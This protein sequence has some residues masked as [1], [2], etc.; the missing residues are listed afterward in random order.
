MSTDLSVVVPVYGSAPIVDELARRLRA[1][2]EASS[3]RWE[4]LLV[5]DDSPDGAWARILEVCEADPRFRGLRLM[6]NQ[7]QHIATLCGL[8]HASGDLVVTMDDDLQHRPEDIPRLVAALDG[9]LDCVMAA[10]PRKRHGPLRNLASRLVSWLNRR[11]YRLPPG[12]RLSTFRVLRGSVVRRM[13]DYRVSRPAVAQLVFLSTSRVA[14][15][16][17]PHDERF[18]GRSGYTLTKSLRLALDHFINASNIPLRAITVTGLAACV[19]S[20]AVGC[21]VLVR[22]LSGEVGV[23]GWASVMVLQ[24]FLFGVLLLGVGMLSEYLHRLLHDVRTGA[25]YAL[26]EDTRSDP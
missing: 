20:F 22:A 7:G 10:F 17:L 23:P 5:D 9:D 8:D 3:W 6:R 14:N 16:D 15:L 21:W 2:L 11:A 13:R 19:A 18:T 26:R 1:V 25:C 12:V 24:A 4:V